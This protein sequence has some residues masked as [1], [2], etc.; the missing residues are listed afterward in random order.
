MR[1]LHRNINI[2]FR[3]T[4]EEQELLHK[5][6]NEVGISNLRAFLLKMALNGYIINLDLKDVRECSRLLRIVSNNVNQIAR[7]VN[8]GGNIYSVNIADV[9]TKLDGIWQ[10]Q[11]KIIRDLSKVL[12]AA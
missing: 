7:H 11:N 12:E 3:V 10:Q 8:S 9:Q 2:G 1:N 4:E 5:R 6:M